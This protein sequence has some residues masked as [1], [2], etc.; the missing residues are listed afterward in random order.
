MQARPSRILAIGEVLWDLL[1]SGPLLGGAPAN[2][3][4]HA[5]ALGGDA[6]LVSRV[7]RDA[8][9]R[10]IL[11]RFAAIGLPTDFI[12]TDTDKATGTVSVEIGA[13]GQPQY[14]IHENIAWDAIAPD[15]NAMKA[16]AAADAVCFGSLAQRSPVSRTAVQALVAASSPRALR[17]FDVNLR[18][19]FFSRGIIESSLALA[20][21]LKLNDAELPVLAEM[22]GLSGDTRRQLAVLAERFALRVVALTRGARGSLLLADGAWSEHP[23][24]AV[25]V[26]DT[27]GAGDAFT[28]ALV[29]GLLAGGP[30][31]AVHQR[32]G[33]VAACVCSHTGPTPS[34]PERF[35]ISKT[36]DTRTKMP[37][38]TVIEPPQPEQPLL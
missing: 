3:V 8:R 29:L 17:V 2:F 1:P 4:L 28:A 16:A 5:H 18:Q 9:G 37:H 34:L 15:P 11:E 6:A 19:A 27:I 22:F 23:G 32:A 14:T 25:E 12:A 24:V 26:R 36:T 38:Q 21:A 33:E 20:N 31:D 7:G 10:E 30:L 35:K 13:D